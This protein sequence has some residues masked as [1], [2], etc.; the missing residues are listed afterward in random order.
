MAIRQA[1]VGVKRSLILILSALVMVFG[2]HGTANARQTPQSVAV[3]ENPTSPLVEDGSI[4]Y[5]ELSK[6]VDAKKAKAGD[7]VTAVLLADLLSHGKIA[8]RQGSKLRGHITES[9]PYS[10]EKPESRLG[11]EFDKILTKGGNEVGFHSVLLALRP[12]PRIVPVPIEGPAP[13]GISAGPGS[14][15]DKR[16]STPQQPTVKTSNTLGRELDARTKEINDLRPSDIDGLS[17]GPSADGSSKIIVSSKR[18][19]KLES[20]VRLEL[21]VTQP[22]PAK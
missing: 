17:L 15:A 7:P 3:Q 21:R 19:V 9:Q 18:T 22:K 2:W 6:T 12:A 10:K 5:L 13:Q 14:S 8:L 1:M 4:L 11:I 20:G 16:Y